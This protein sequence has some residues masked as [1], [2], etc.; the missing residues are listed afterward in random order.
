MYNCQLYLNYRELTANEQKAAENAILW[1]SRHRLGAHTIAL[2]S[3]RSLDR[4][5][6]TLY[7]TIETKHIVFYR[8]IRYQGSPLDYYLDKVLPE[9]KV[10]RWLF[11]RQAWV[12][13]KPSFGFHV[14]DYDV[15]DFLQKQS[16]KL[17]I[18]RKLHDNIEVSA[19]KTHIQK[20]I[21]VGRR[22]ALRA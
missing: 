9:L 17:L 3:E 16:K 1:L 20:Q 6:K 11:P 4:E 2:L 21:M 12:G 22:I 15:E 10:E 5:S 18:Y 19:N 8:K 7:V 13:R 14:R